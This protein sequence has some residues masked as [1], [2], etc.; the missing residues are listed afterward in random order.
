MGVSMD[1]LQNMVVRHNELRYQKREIEGEMRMVA[2]DIVGR[3]IDMK[4]YQCF[5]VKWGEVD[6]LIHRR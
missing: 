5:N 4:Q 1:K 6:K 2:E 3:L